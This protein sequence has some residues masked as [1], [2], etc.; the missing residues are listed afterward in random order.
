MVIVPFWEHAYTVADARW[1]LNKPYLTGFC[2]AR[3]CRVSGK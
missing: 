2:K 1:T 3:V